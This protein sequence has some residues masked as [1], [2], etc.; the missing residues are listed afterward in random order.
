[1]ALEMTNLINK[2]VIVPSSAVEN[3]GFG[4]IMGTV[5]AKGLAKK[6]PAIQSNEG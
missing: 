3:M 1:M 5:Q 2:V 4:G 6:N